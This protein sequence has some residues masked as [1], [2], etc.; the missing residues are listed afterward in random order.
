MT[1]ILELP[2]H[3]IAHSRAGDKGNVSNISLIAYNKYGWENI[4]MNATESKVLAIFKHLGTSDVKRYELPK[5]TALNFV[6]Q[7]ALA[8]GV[9]SSLR[10]D[11]HGKTLSSYLLYHLKLK[12]TLDML[13]D[14]SPYRTNFFKG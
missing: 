10:L 3:S 11:R 14:N 5:L 4:K 6:I 7:D 9:N 13:P 12:I 2:V 1:K 8:G